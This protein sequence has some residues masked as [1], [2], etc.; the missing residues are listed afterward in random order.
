MNTT[1]TTENAV[2]WF[3]AR[4]VTNYLDVVNRVAVSIVDTRTA[5]GSTVRFYNADDEEFMTLISN[6]VSTLFD[7]LFGVGDVE[8]AS[9]TAEY[10]E[11]STRFGSILD[12]EVEKVT[13]SS[14]PAGGPKRAWK[15]YSSS[16]PPLLLRWSSSRRSVRCP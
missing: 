11:D 16:F 15:R 6:S 1:P 5:E 12:H 10:D 9:V 7:P 13:V 4:A 14:Q 2:A 8:L 3:N